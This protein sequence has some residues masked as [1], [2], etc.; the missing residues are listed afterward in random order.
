VIDLQLVPIER[1]EVRVLPL[2]PHG[3]GVGEGLEEERDGAGAQLDQGT[4]Q[5]VEGARLEGIDEGGD[6]LGHGRVPE[7]RIPPDHPKH[8][9]R[10]PPPDVAPRHLVIGAAVAEG[11]REGEGPH[12]GFAPAPLLP[13]HDL[14]VEGGVPL[15]LQSRGD[16][17]QLDG[18]LL[19]IDAVEHAP[20]QVARLLG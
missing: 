20:D 1:G 14:E 13:V 11:L 8:H 4:L 5:L 12:D 16:P 6:Q 7:L 19:V 10:R 17:L 2:R 9:R 15:M 3:P 18:Q